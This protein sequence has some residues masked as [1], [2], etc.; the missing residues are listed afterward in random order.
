MN[1]I[2]VF[3]YLALITAA[4]A[5]EVTVTILAAIDLDHAAAVGLKKEVKTDMPDFTITHLYYPDTKEGVSIFEGAHP[6]PF[7]ARDGRK[8]LGEVKDVVAGRSITW[9][10]WS[11]DVAG[12]TEYGAEVLLPSRN[13]CLRCPMGRRTS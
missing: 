12:S 10:C 1:A 4:G 6:N 5:E 2:R 8:R 7:S 13:P 9:D 11:Q 3:L